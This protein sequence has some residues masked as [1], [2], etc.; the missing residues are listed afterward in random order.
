[1]GQA[2]SPYKPDN[3]SCAFGAA[4]LQGPAYS[5]ISIA[6]GNDYPA[7]RHRTISA[8]ELKNLNSQLST[9]NSLFILKE[10]HYGIL[11]KQ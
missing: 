4:L 3:P 7:D 6:G 8:A 9:L 1:M 10:N 11:H 5:G 2:A